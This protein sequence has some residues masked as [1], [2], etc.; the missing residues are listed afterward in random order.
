MI[1][2]VHAPYDFLT[3][4]ELRAHTYRIDRVDITD[5]PSNQ[6]KYFFRAKGHFRT[7]FQKNF[8]SMFSGQDGYQTT[9]FMSLIIMKT[10]LD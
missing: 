9:P 7:F 6:E 1:R 5:K 3:P 4:K 8:F 2:D 10:S